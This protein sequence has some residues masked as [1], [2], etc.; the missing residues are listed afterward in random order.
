MINLLCIILFCALGMFFSKEAFAGSVDYLSNQSAEYM[1]TFNRNAATDSGD[2]V[3]YNPAGVMKLQNGLY[4]N[5]S[6][7]Y[8][9]KDYASE[10]E[11][12]S[13]AYNNGEYESD[14]PSIIPNAYVVYKQESWAAFAAFTVPAGGGE[15]EYDEG[16]PLVRYY[17]N[18]FTG[19]A[20]INNIDV[21]KASSMYLAGTMGGVYKINEMF[22]ASLGAR[23]IYGSK[24]FE[25][26][27]K[28]PTAFTAGDKYIKV[29]LDS[30]GIGGI[31]GLNVTPVKDVNVGIRYETVTKMEWDTSVIAGTT[32]FRNLVAGLGYA[33]GETERKDLPALLGLGVSYDILPELK[34][35]PCFTYYFIKQANWEHYNG[36]KG[37]ED[38]DNGWEAGLAVEYKVMPELLVSAGYQHTVTGGNKDTWSEFGHMALDSNSFGLG[39]K[40]EV[41]PGVNLNLGLSWIKYIDGTS[42]SNYTY[43]KDVKAIALGVDYKIL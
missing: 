23:Y 3:N 12:T 1:R 10:D 6:G 27:A 17:V 9:A 15:V 7:Q 40:F 33:D 37:N 31:I 20:D 19:G 24:T 2:A 36:T 28:N 32:N 29:D 13:H 16:T 8:M 34:V 26:T 4:V 35:S 38:Y 41:T 22:S 42:K 39:G 21:F 18:M 5:A 11:T 14:T 43:K 25:V 30:W